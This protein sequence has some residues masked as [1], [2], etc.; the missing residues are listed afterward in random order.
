MFVSVSAS[1]GVQTQVD[2]LNPLPFSL[3]MGG[4]DGAGGGVAAAI[5]RGGG[6][7]I[8]RRDRKEQNRHCLPPCSIAAATFAVVVSCPLAPTIEERRQ[9]KG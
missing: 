6:R 9:E 5:S 8:D 7:G 1:S 3:G 4:G 2:R